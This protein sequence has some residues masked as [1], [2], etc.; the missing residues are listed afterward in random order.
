MIMRQHDIF[1]RLV[2]DGAYP[3]DHFVGHRRRRLGVEHEAAVIADDYCGIGIAFGGE[4]IEIGADLGEGEFLL[5][6]IRGGCKT[7]GSHRLDSL[8]AYYC[9]CCCCW[10]APS[11]RRCAN[12]IASRS[13]SRSPIWLARIRTSAASRSAL[14]SSFNPRWA[15][16]TARNASSGLA[17]FELVDNTMIET[18]AGTGG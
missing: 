6:H 2:G 13:T 17:K 1:D 14:C 4:G 8:Y 9:C 7:L 5:G 10:S 3:L 11:I 12:A 15:S 18:S 16:T